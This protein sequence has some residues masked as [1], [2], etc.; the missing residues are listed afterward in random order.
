MAKPKWVEAIGDELERLMEE[1]D[2]SADTVVRHASTRIS[3]KTVSNVRRGR[4][5][6]PDYAPRGESVRAVFS[7]FGEA[8]IQALRKAGRD[9]WA[10]ML[11]SQLDDQ[12]LADVLRGIDP[13]ILRKFLND[14]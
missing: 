6:S 3:S 2:W 12:K 1:R 9:D 7:A 5:G 8:G 4:D 13:D 14:K 11:E 10:E